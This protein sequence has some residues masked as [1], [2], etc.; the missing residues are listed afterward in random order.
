M[1]NGHLLRNFQLCTNSLSISVLCHEAES[2]RNA[3]IGAA[4]RYPEQRKLVQHH[5]RLVDSTIL[6]AVLSG[7]AHF[8]HTQIG[9]GNLREK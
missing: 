1:A 6:V 9:G 2:L 8:L 3:L 5:T 4:V 7:P